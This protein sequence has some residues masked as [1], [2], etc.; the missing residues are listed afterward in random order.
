MAFWQAW[1]FLLVWMVC[2]VSHHRLFD[3]NDQKL[4]NKSCFQAGPV[5]ETQKGPAAGYLGFRQLVFI[6]IF[7]VSGLSYR[8][9]WLVVP[10]VLSWISNDSLCWAFFIVFLTFK[11][12][13]IPVARIEVADEQRV[14]YTGAVRLVRHP[15]YAERSC[16][17]SL[18]PWRWDPRWLCLFPCR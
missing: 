6:G 3:K 4:L 2:M 17:C 11:K 12:I 1:A 10:F 16:C 14:N 8:F 15:M 13:P 7:V 5:A 9:P 18:H